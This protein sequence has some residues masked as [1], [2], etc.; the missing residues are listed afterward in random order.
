[1]PTERRPSAG[2]EL[3]ESWHC[4]DPAPTVSSPAAKPWIQRQPGRTM[5]PMSELAVIAAGG[6]IGA[7]GR[8]SLSLLVVRRLGAE[9]H[10]GTL[11]VNILGCF[12]LGALLSYIE[13]A[14]GFS[15]RLQL[16]LA[17]GVLG[18]FTTFS[19]FGAETVGL[20]RAGQWTS[21]LGH[22]GL[23]VIVGLAAVM[24][25]ANMANRFAN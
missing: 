14:E 24:L 10:Q 13:Q 18:A 25:G 6:A 11:L 2:P 17:T 12:F 5:Q 22:V 9:S 20:V 15:P 4:A 3:A 23:N 8:Y 19:T 21:A 1:V 16:F 7:V